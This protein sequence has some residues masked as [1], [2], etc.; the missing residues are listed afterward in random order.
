MKQTTPDCKKHETSTNASRDHTPEA[1]MTAAKATQGNTGTNLGPTPRVESRQARQQ[2][3]L[4][5]WRRNFARY[6]PFTGWRVPELVE[7]AVVAFSRQI[8]LE[9][10]MARSGQ[11]AALAGGT[12]LAIDFNRGIWRSSTLE[13]LEQRRL[14]A[15]TVGPMEAYVDDSWANATEGQV[16]S[17]KTS[18]GEEI[19]LVYGYD[20]FSSLADGVA[21]LEEGGT[22][23]IAEGTYSE[24]LATAGKGLMIRA[25][26]DGA[27][28][29]TLDG[30]FLGKGDTLDF[31][32]PSVA[33]YDRFR[34]S[35]GASVFELGS[36]TLSLGVVGDLPTDGLDLLGLVT[37]ERGVS[38][39]PSGTVYDST[40]RALSSETILSSSRLDFRFDRSS[41]DYEGIF[42]TP[43]IDQ[44]EYAISGLGGS[45][46]LDDGLTFSSN[47]LPSLVYVYDVWAGS[48]P[49]ATVTYGSISGTFGT[50]AFGTIGD[51]LVG[52]AAAGT[53]QVIAGS[54][55]IYNE[56]L[57]ITQDVT[58]QGV[59][60]G[61]VSNEMGADP[62]AAVLDGTALSGYGITINGP[63]IDLVLQ[64]FNL[65]NWYDGALIV[66]GGGSATVTNVTLNGDLSG[67][68]SVLRGMRLEAGTLAIDKSV[69]QAANGYGANNAI[70][71]TGGTF[72]MSASSVTGS[73]GVNQAGLVVS[74]GSAAV[75]TSYVAGNFYGTIFS[76][77]ATGS[78]TGS[79]LSGNTVS[80]VRNIA[81]GGVIVDAS[82]NWWGVT[83][84]ADV[85]AKTYSTGGSRVDI[86][87]YLLDGTD[88]GNATAGFQGDYSQLAV[89]ALGAQSGATGR[90]QEG[91]NSIA[92][93]SLT[94]INR[95]LFVNNGTYTGATDVN[96]SLTLQAANL[97]LAANFT[98]SAAVTLEEVTDGGGTVIGVT[99]VG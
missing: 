2:Q 85:L 81:T 26:G 45:L 16:L 46:S 58:I 29:V 53:V 34:L 95:L 65:Q 66:Q 39:G 73:S 93:G 70:Q 38:V 77:S 89:T 69:F 25:G 18:A 62:D 4:A 82:N 43:V 35:T 3:R 20:A 86:T 74:G 17:W 49:G 32:L 8:G 23:S 67:V 44:S 68:A 64:N 98:T 1:T 9:R 22:L 90:I 15:L 55:G 60:P 87:P 94:G 42:L 24:V 21:A 31:D 37:S 59:E 76:N 28:E 61:A 6:L 99:G 80:A 36:A 7:S 41:G 92:N 50:D 79:D 91:V 54:S 71:V 97:S 52:V 56:Q 96:Q 11:R 33:E 40:G 63:G 19:P 47:L 12:A 84:E 83:P 30:L 13:S 88:T 72:T 75:T 5:A 14:M 48:A 27:A 57:A 10:V 51:G 78:V